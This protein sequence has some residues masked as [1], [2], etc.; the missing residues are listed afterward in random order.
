MNDLCYKYS[1]DSVF[2]NSFDCVFVYK[3]IRCS[4]KTEIKVVLQY[5]N[6]KL[7]GNIIIYTPE[8]LVIN[9]KQ[10]IF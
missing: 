9:E 3:E 6:E 4:N 8:D 1:Q 2:L 5:T 7:P 10:Y